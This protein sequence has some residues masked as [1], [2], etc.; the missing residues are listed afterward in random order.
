[1]KKMFLVFLA[2]LLLACEPSKKEIPTAEKKFA[3]IR[4]AF[5]ETVLTDKPKRIA[6]IGWGN[7]DVPLALGVVP[8]GM[9]K[10]NYGVLDGTG[11]LPWTAER[12]AELG[13]P[14][15]SLFDDTDGVDFEALSDVQP[16]V[17]LAA[18][19]GITRN[20]YELLSKIGPTIPYPREPWQTLWREQILINAA[21][22][23]LEAEGQRIVT[24]LEAFIEE[25]LRL[26]PELKGKTGAFVYF[27]PS[28]LSKISVYSPKDPRTMWLTDL[29]LVLP[30][31]IAK[32]AEKS[33]SFYITL[34]AE[35]ADL[36]AEADILLTWVLGDAKLLEILQGDSLIGGIPAIQRGSV[37]LLEENP[38][39]ASMTPSPLSIPWSLDEYLQLIA[40]A[41][42]NLP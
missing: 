37:V 27:D 29:G 32:L 39:A 19:S 36:L 1:M 26:Y 25:K 33:Q 42:E 38:L 23:G 12:I 6:A 5:G 17:I 18:Y 3:V 8:V 28:D 40:K 21:G 11:I 4:H 41:A 24:D 10:A 16:D 14:S 34:S 2:G 15:P 7:Q 30:E 20:E 31:G 9:S 22:M 35:N 13:G